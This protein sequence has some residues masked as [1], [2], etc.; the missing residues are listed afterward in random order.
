V[1]AVFFDLDNTLTP[2]RECVERLAEHFARDWREQLAGSNAAELRPLLVAADQGGYNSRRAEDLREQ[3]AWRD[4]PG[5]D[6]LEDYWQTQ[7]PLASV[8]RPGALRLLEALTAAGTRLGCVTNGGVRGQ[9]AKLDQLGLTPWFD[10]VVISEVVGCKKP[11]PRIFAVATE[12]LDVR[13]DESWFVGD[14][15]ANDVLGARRFGMQAVWIRDGHAWPADESP[16]THVIDAL[17]ELFGVLDL[18]ARDG[19]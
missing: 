1:R 7:L 2:R 6:A 13:A 15:P 8:L 18:E 12:L 4:A 14:H 17:G 10:V 11:D 3:L 19:A 9:S 16:P 5:V